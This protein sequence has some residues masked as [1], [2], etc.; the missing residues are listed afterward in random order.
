MEWGKGEEGLTGVAVPWGGD[1][2][3]KRPLGHCRQEGAL[4]RPLRRGEAVFKELKAESGSLGDDLWVLSLL[5][6]CSLCE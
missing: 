6:A 5:N 3:L 2:A 1:T 4:Q